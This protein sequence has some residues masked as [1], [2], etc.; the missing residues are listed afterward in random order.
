MAK[1]TNK[2]HQAARH[3]IAAH[4][5]LHALDPEGSCASCLQPLDPSK[6]LYLPRREV[7]DGLDN[8]DKELL[9]KHKRFWGHKQSENK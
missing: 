7:D 4:E 8:G 3:Y 9:D 6:D 5:A 2:T 1:F